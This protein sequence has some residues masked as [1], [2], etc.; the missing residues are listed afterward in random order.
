[1]EKISSLNTQKLLVVVDTTKA[2]Q[3]YFVI[4][5]FF[6]FLLQKR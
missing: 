5:Y 1:M 3:E 2:R 6:A 4:L